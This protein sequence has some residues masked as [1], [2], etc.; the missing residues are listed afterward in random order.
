[1]P[2]VRSH[3]R[4]PRGFPSFRGGRGSSSGSA[5]LGLVLLVVLPPLLFVSLV[6]SLAE[7]SAVFRWGA[8]GAVYLFFVLTLWGA[9]A[10]PEA[11]IAAFARFVRSAWPVPVVVGLLGTGVWCGWSK[12]LDNA[13]HAEL[14]QEQQV[15]QSIER[16]RTEQAK[17]DAIAQQDAEREAFARLPAQVHIDAAHKALA[18]GFKPATKTGGNLGEAER[19]LL[20]VVPWAPESA[21]A[22]AL[23]RECAARRDRDHLI[24][25]WLSADSGAHAAAQWHLD[26]LSP[27]SAEASSATLK[28]L[29]SR[30]ESARQKEARRLAQEQRRRERAARAEQESSGGDSL[31]C[32]DGSLSPSCSCSGSHRGCCSHH[33][34]VCGCR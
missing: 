27:G 18:D 6:A 31:L 7:S 21:Q 5:T 34:G 8:A 10:K 4:R 9:F 13:R 22:A 2:W 3:Y 17:Q 15:A 30:I 23:R 16:A 19:H 12:A 1:M 29:R 26:Q 33:G 14:V 25:A 11:P 24:Q 32:C 20:A 28:R